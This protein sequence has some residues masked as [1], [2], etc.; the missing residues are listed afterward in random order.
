MFKPYFSIFC[1]V[2]IV[3]MCMAVVVLIAIGWD[4][5]IFHLLAATDWLNISTS[6]GVGR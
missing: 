6:L 2:S 4:F 1:T 3:A 5:C